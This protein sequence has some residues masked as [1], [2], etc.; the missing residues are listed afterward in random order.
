MESVMSDKPKE[1]FLYL[2]KEYTNA[3]KHQHIEQSFCILIRHKNTSFH[4]S[5]A[6]DRESN[7]NNRLD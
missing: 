6:L 3:P 1:T 5:K 4:Y 2:I 7:Y